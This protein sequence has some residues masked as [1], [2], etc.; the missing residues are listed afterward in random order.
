MCREPLGGGDAHLQQVAQ[1][2]V[3]VRGRRRHHPVHRITLGALR[4]ANR[5]GVMV[6]PSVNSRAQ[7]TA[8]GTR[9]SASRRASAAVSLLGPREVPTSSHRIRPA[10][11]A[12]CECS[13]TSAITCR[14]GHVVQHGPFGRQ[15]ARAASVVTLV[16]RP[17]SPDAATSAALP[18]MAPPQVFSTKGLRSGRPQGSDPDLTDRRP[19]LARYD[20]SGCLAPDGGPGH[21]EFRALALRVI[22]REP[23]RLRGGS[24]AGCGEIR[25]SSAAACTCSGDSTVGPEV[26]RPATSLVEH[27]S[28]SPTSPLGAPLPVKQSA[29]WTRLERTFGSRSATAVALAAAPRTVEAR[30]RPS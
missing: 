25:S 23:A 14:P 1:P 28:T 12:R 8:P 21:R 30:D 20:Y 17:C 16:S 29:A 6:E 7:A 27:T 22:R 5:F 13:G 3:R 18:A 24:V 15:V 11:S 10:A 19:W 9:S 4:A 26:S 2:R